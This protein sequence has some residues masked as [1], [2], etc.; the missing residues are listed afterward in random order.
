MNLY[1]IAISIQ[2]SFFSLYKNNYSTLSNSTY[3]NKHLSE[4]IS[5]LNS[6]KT[7]SYHIVK[8]TPEIISLG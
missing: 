1:S 8:Q 2:V 4:G 6:G 7:H 5:I 3:Q